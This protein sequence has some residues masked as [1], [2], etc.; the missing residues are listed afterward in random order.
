M[1]GRY[2][3]YSKS[4]KN[5]Y[6]KP[7]H[8]TKGFYLLI[9]LF[10]AG[11]GFI[12]W[13]IQRAEEPTLTTQKFTDQ[14]TVPVK[15]AKITYIDGEIQLMQDGQEW[16]DATL[17]DQIDAAASVKTGEKTK[18]TI[19]LPDKSIVRLSENTEMK[20][21][22]LGMANIAMEQKSGTAFHRVSDKSTATYKVTK[23]KIEIS[24]IGTAFNTTS[25]G[26]NI[27]LAVTEN[28]VK[29]KIIE[30][31]NI[32]NIR[33]IEAGTGAKIS[34]TSQ[35]EEMI[36]TDDISTDDL[37]AN[38]WYSWNLEK[39]KEN[40]FLVGIFE[41]A[42]P[43]S[44]TEPAESEFETD[45]SKITIKGT[46]DPEAEIFRDGKEI[47]NK[48]GA[49]ETEINLAEGEN[50]IKIT[51][52]KGKNKNQK[53]FV[54]TSKT[55]EARIALSGERVNNGVKL[56]WKMEDSSNI[57]NFKTLMSADANPIFPGA[58]FHTVNKDNFQ[59]TWDNLKDGKYY[60]RICA[61]SEDE[62]C[63]AYSGNFEI[64][65]DAQSAGEEQTSGTI[66]LSGDSTSP[67]Q[68][69]LRWKTNN[70]NATKGFKSIYSENSNVIFPG[71]SHHLLTSAN[72]SADTWGNLQSGKTYYFRIC[73][74]EGSACGVYS[75]EVAVTVE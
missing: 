29:V 39:D 17:D 47:D 22:E 6:K 37:L 56:T 21:D 74:N 38:D 16:R 33:T 46:T 18:A 35:L 57:Q 75:N 3:S 2:H 65:I 49:F 54:I 45:K 34:P 50:K 7:F 11:F 31:E 48:N 44:I 52:T 30:N 64:T 51:V 61:F 36:K 26:N 10:L 19:E 12:Y 58:Y 25:A 4:S 41:K 59:D 68:V 40:N 9:V 62:Q 69:N 63:L 15:T 32:L 5:Y 60:F 13:S 8:K 1:V 67:G 70:L 28:R 24:A 23:G 72:D 66:E 14:E 73:Q 42:V 71:N 55:A 27:D 43:I 53:T 20:F